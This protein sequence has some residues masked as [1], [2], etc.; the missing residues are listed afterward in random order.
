M[1]LEMHINY[2]EHLWFVSF[3]EAGMSTKHNAGCLA[4]LNCPH[5]RSSPSNKIA[6][7]NIY[8]LAITEWIMSKVYHHSP[9]YKI[10]LGHSPNFYFSRH[11]Q[12]SRLLSCSR[13]DFLFESYKAFFSSPWYLFWNSRCRDHSFQ[14]QR[15][16]QLRTFE[17]WFIFWIFL[18]SGFLITGCNPNFWKVNCSCVLLQV[19]MWL[20]R[21]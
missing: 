10:Y 13:A 8:F 20:S 7:A 14:L 3:I 16:A 6:A 18:L 2:M 5:I 17:I 1:L 11:R 12:W 4:R 9:R 21:P 19:K 15:F